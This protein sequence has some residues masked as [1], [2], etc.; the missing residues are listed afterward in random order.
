MWVSMNL[1]LTGWGLNEEQVVDLLSLLEMPLLQ[2]GMN[3][4]TARNLGSEL[5]AELLQAL[6]SDSSGPSLTVCSVCQSLQGS[7]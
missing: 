5:M 3:E 7:L 6:S 2:A 4:V 1:I